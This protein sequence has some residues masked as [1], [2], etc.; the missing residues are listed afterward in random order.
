MVLCRPATNDFFLLINLSTI[1]LINHVVVWIQ[2]LK[3]KIAKCHDDV[4][5]CPSPK[6]IQFIVTEE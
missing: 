3:K 1:F 5:E 4:P 2:N 6:D